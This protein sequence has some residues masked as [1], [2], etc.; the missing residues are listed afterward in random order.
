MEG[1]YTREETKKE[2]ELGE[3]RKEKSEDLEDTIK[4]YVREGGYFAATE[5]MI[6]IPIFCKRICINRVS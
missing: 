5:K 6:V 3:E 2:K 4:A 1:I